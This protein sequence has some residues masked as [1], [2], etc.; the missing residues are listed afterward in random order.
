MSPESPLDGKMILVVDDE[1]DI[2]DTVEEELPMCRIR[3]V[4]DHETAL[5]HLLGYTWDAVVLDIMGVDGFKLLKVATSRGFPAVMLT[6]HALT[7]EALKKSMKLG[8][9]SFLPK[10]QISDL[11]D[12]LVEVVTDGGK[13]P[14]IRFF[15]KLGGFFDRKFGPDWKQSDDF[16]REFEEK[17]RKLEQ[18]EDRAPEVH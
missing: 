8:A 5:Q 10:E 12:F 13:S 7:P 14:W 9:V 1:P 4:Q 6:A 15:D 16:F 2:L 3:K 11:H 17:V 18:Q